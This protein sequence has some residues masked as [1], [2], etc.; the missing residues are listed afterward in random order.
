[1]AH[2]WTIKENT[3]LFGC[4]LSKVSMLKW[5]SILTLF[6]LIPHTLF[7]QSATISGFIT[8]KTTGEPL[9]AA[10]VYDSASFAG[11]SSNN[12]GFYSL[13][14]EQGSGTILV[15]F[16]GYQ[17]LSYRITLTGDTVMNFSLEPGVELEEV[18]VRSVRTQSDF[19]KGRLTIPITRLNELPALGGETDLIKALTTLPG[20]AAANEGSSGMVVRG[21]GTDQNLFI[22]DGIPVY[23]TGHL[24]DFISVFNPDAVKRLDFY[25]GPFPA[26]YGGRLSSVTDITFRDGN[27]R[28]I[29]KYFEIGVINSK[30]TIEG[31]IDDKTTFLLS[32]RS[33]YLDLFTPIRNAIT[34]SREKF[35]ST[36]EIPER[37][38]KFVMYTFGDL[39]FKVKHR[40]NNNHSISANLFHSIDYYRIFDNSSTY[41]EK[42]KY[43]LFNTAIS[44]KSDHV[45]GSRLFAS[46]MLGYTSNTGK[47]DD[48]ETTYYD[49]T[50][51]DPLTHLPTRK[52][53]FDSSERFRQESIIGDIASTADFTLF[54]NNNHTIS[55]GAAGTLSHFQPGSYSLELRDTLDNIA[56]LKSLF[57][58]D[59]MTAAEGSLY[60]EDEWK[61]GSILR[62]T[63]GL[64]FNMFTSSGVFFNSLDPRLSIA[65]DMK[66]AGS[67]VLSWSRMTQNI[68]ALMRNDILRFQTVWV[69]S[70]AG[71]P[72]EK[73]TQLTLGFMHKS[74]SDG[75]SFG[76]DFYYKRMQ[77]LVEYKINYLTKYSFYQW[78]NS[79]VTNGIGEVFGGEFLAEKTT[80]KVTGNINYTLSWSNRQF[81]GLNGGEWF[82][83]FF[84][85]RHLFNISGSVRLNEAWK[86]SFFW[87]AG[88]G[89]R[90][91]FPSAH[92]GSNPYTPYDYYLYEGI[93]SHRLPVYHRLDLAAE[94]QKKTEKGDTYG[95][96]FSLYNAYCRFNAYY[97]YVDTY[98]THDNDNNVTGTASRVRKLALLPIIPAINFYYR[99]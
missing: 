19:L 31:P 33:T 24:F 34:K 57:N 10:S 27:T 90:I 12:K 55:F 64:R 81:A 21:G 5:L 41:D 23:S 40:F 94:W 88:S 4:I 20:I 22:L 13:S 50:W 48:E 26:K 35:E 73:A 1:M 95:L 67:L 29:K 45:F 17:S 93:N 97:I 32:L 75:Y 83:A 30:F 11:T 42:Y 28:E 37:S 44:V 6:L 3:T 91:N 89:H 16:V 77:N 92:V 54:A 96:K 47:L 82:P 80:G 9:I 72:P 39:N 99:F 52:T 25:K 51:W 63:G 53:G 46:T 65:A 61:F 87:T 86:L 69:P 14:L 43:S 7:S 56:P 60:I 59:P 18:T 78:E 71:V 66:E 74:K 79:L 58:N 85:R 76:A 70:I 2:R 15:S 49:Y 8:D 98:N 62:L 36:S 38:K 68:H 84:D